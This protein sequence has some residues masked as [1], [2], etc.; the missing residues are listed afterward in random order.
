MSRIDARGS[1]TKINFGN[2]LE[3]R[4]KNLIEASHKVT[5]IQPETLREDTQKL[6]RSTL[7][8][9]AWKL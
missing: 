1:I 3:N 4:Q 8:L 2:R 9:K 7:A 5:N 6:K